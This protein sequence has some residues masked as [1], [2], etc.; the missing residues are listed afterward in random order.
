[1]T[2]MGGLHRKIKGLRAKQRKQQQNDKEIRIDDNRLPLREVNINRARNPKNNSN[3]KIQYEMKNDGTKS[4]QINT[5]VDETPPSPTNEKPKT[6]DV[7]VSIGM[8]KLTGIIKYCPENNTENNV[9]AYVSFKNVYPGSDTDKLTME[10]F[11]PSS[12]IRNICRNEKI[13]YYFA[14]WDNDQSNQR[15]R[16]SNQTNTS[17]RFP[18]TLK[19][20]KG[21]RN[22][23]NWTTKSSSF[24]PYILEIQVGL[25]HA[26]GEMTKL[27]QSLLAIDGE[28]VDKTFYL[29]VHPDQDFVNTIK[30]N[31][32]RNKKSKSF[33]QVWKKGFSLDKNP[34]LLMHLKVEL[35]RTTKQVS[36]IENTY[37]LS[38]E[39]SIFEGIDD[40]NTISEMSENDDRM[41]KGILKSF[42]V[43]QIY[44]DPNYQFKTYDEYS[45]N[46]SNISFWSSEYTYTDEEDKENTELVYHR[47]ADV[48]YYQVCNGVTENNSICDSESEASFPLE[49]YNLGKTYFSFNNLC[50]ACKI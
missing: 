24:V 28:A 40:D 48:H 39:S 47:P 6:L 4:K 22:D 23:S 43:N 8:Q 21:K 20:N 11:V 44:K 42:D 7:T 36:F 38:E 27:G 12:P 2:T 30:P 10:A 37:Y 46:A 34:T 32:K 14:T 31:K 17:M 41:P 25:I 35:T 26:G 50:G 29:P 1:M 45:S 33:R 19:S 13:D 15:R 49:S 9:K 3:T 5:I 18:L 16:G